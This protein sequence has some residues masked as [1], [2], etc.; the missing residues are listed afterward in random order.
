[1]SLRMKWINIFLFLDSKFVS[2]L[3]REINSSLSYQHFVKLM[4]PGNEVSIRLSFHSSYIHL[5]NFIILNHS[6]LR[7]H[8]LSSFNGSLSC[9]PGMVFINLSCSLPIN[10]ILG[11][12]W[13]AGHNLAF[14]F[15][16]S[17]KPG[18]IIIQF[19]ILIACFL[20]FLSFS[21]IFVT[22]KKCYLMLSHFKNSFGFSLHFILLP[23]TWL[24]Q[25][26]CLVL[27]LVLVSCTKG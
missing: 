21:Y 8:C 25:G 9:S 19:E 18:S 22:L 3:D 16:V 17:G 2:P 27:L 23:V 24:W 20:I 11:G 4:N 12:L 13:R 7:W 26:I 15:C 1:M 5:L 10:E 6:T 14:F